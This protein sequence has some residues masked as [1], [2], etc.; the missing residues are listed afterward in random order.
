MTAEELMASG[1]DLTSRMRR[2]Y[3]IP[4]A[5]GM[6]LRPLNGRHQIVK[7]FLLFLFAVSND[8]TPI[9]DLKDQQKL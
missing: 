8:S 6:L 5:E 1:R 2:N 9:Q 4:A 3:N 7:C